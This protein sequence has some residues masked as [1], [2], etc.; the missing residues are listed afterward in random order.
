MKALVV[1]GAGV[2]GKLIVKGLLQRGYQVTDEDGYNGD[3]DPIDRRRYG[4]AGGF[5]VRSQ[6]PPCQRIRRGNRPQGRRRRG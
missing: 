4:R 1:G 5:R 6:A 3:S 2:T